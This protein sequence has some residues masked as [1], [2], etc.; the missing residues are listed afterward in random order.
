MT[1][2]CLILLLALMPSPL[3]ADMAADFLMG[4]VVKSD[5]WKMDRV[6]DRET[7][8]GNV[9]FRN[10]GKSIRIEDQSHSSGSIFSNSSSIRRLI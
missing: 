10:G 5:K 9:S 2:V 3:R 7:F 6:H 1:K 4:S 8:E